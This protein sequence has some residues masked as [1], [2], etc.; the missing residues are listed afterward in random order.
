MQCMN[1]DLDVTWWEPRGITSRRKHNECMQLK[2]FSMRV[3]KH[4]DDGRVDCSSHTVLHLLL[5]AAE[6]NTKSKDAIQDNT[7]WED[8]RSLRTETVALVRDVLICN[9]KQSK[10]TTDWQHRMCGR[11]GH[12]CTGCLKKVDLIEAHKD[13]DSP[14]YFSL[15]A[16]ALTMLGKVVACPDLE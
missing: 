12:F 4:D 11:C 8:L 7:L 5:H 10:R 15:L 16:C 9:Q 1:T 3:D 13:T 14:K 2:L 6:K